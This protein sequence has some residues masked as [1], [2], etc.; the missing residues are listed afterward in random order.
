MKSYKPLFI[1]SL[2]SLWCVSAAWAQSSL[3]RGRITD[4]RTKETLPGVNVSVPGTY[5]GAVTDIDGVY[6]IRDLAPGD[7]DLKASLIG[8]TVQ[9]RTG[10]HVEQGKTTQIDF[11]LEATVLALGQ[12]V[13]V[14][15]KKPLFETD[16]TASQQ[17]ISSEEIEQKVVESV[18]DLV[19]EQL[20]VVVQDNKIHIRGGRADE[21]LY[22]IDGQ[23]IK[24]PLSGYSNT[25]YVNAAAVKDL[26]VITGGFDAEYGQAMSGVVD[27]ETKEGA[28]H[29]SGGIS[30]KSD[31]LAKG[32]FPSFNTDIVQLTLGGPEPLTRRLLPAIGLRLPGKLNFFL[33][34]YGNI[35]DTYLPQADQLYPAKA[36]YKKFAP[37]Q[38]N[39]WHLMGKLS[40]E[41]R[42]GRKVSLS[43]DRSVNINQGY[44]TSLA[45]DIGGFP[46]DYSKML[47]HYNTLTKEANLT[48]LQWIHT[49]NSRTFYRMTLSRF[50]TSI[51][52]AVQNKHWSAYQEGLDLL[53]I[54]Y[55]PDSEGNVKTRYGDGFYDTGDAEGW[56]DYFSDNWT[57]KTDLTTQPN[58]KHSIKAGAE[59]RYTDMQVVDINAPWYGE[60]GL[61]RNHDYFR[62]YPNDGA[63][64]LQDRITY[65]GMI[66]NI[67]LRYDYWFPGKFVDDAIKDSNTVTITD[68][69]RVKYKDE[70][71]E[72]WGLRGKSHLSPRLGISH[73][74]TDNDVLYLHYGH[75]SQQPKGQYVYAKLR[76]TSEATYQL[77]GNPNLKPTTTV[78]Y[79]L[80]LKH[81][82][83][84]N[85]TLEIKAYYK[86]MFDYPTAATVRKYSPRYGNISFLMYVNMDYARARGIEMRFRR[87]YSQFLSGN[88]DF[89][90]ALATGKSSTPNTNLLVAAGKVS[91][92]PLGESR[93]SWDRPYRLSTDLYFDMPEKANIRLAGVRLPEK[94]GVTLRWEYESGKRYRR[95]IDVANNVYEKDEYGSLSDP[96]MRLDLKWYK[97]FELF[98]T[99]LSVLIEAENVFN[100]KVPRIINP[101]TG[102]P[103]QPGD[104]IPVSW[105][106]DPDDL[107]AT[108]PARYD[109]PRRVMTGLEIRF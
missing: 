43:H 41:I 38:E 3:I 30:V 85:Q 29:Y 65:D 91:E 19:G 8:Y 93:L 61:G 26:K 104:V 15:G 17:H 55:I 87:R 69:A 52:S 53:P 49:L 57:I 56:Y 80:G 37:R 79:E 90:Y 59:A 21:S 10:V 14:I 88:I 60:S 22:I 95:I 45:T 31:N 66:V 99:H 44:F 46:Y 16:I 67:G 68:A 40:W 51:H 18:T 101:V 84:A 13:E 28:D 39:D 4:K 64:Y 78:A 89:T 63:L 106:D 36:S 42:P 74:V 58:D 2:V 27:I 35:S 33:S 72:L 23:S 50:F 82:F 109:W 9:V 1:L 76:S 25:L 62:V 12:S 98:K 71:F 73:P 96:W 47:D 32:W 6:Q 108:N 105:Y 81:R 54:L 70:T 86:D 20:G 92:K 107:P 7:Y 24:D 97:E 5:K 102:R 11:S 75:F 34:G 77:F 83:N 94:W 103:Y 48:T 100:A